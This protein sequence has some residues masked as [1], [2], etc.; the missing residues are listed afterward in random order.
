VRSLFQSIQ[1]QVGKVASGIDSPLLGELPVEQLAAPTLGHLL[2]EDFEIQRPTSQSL[3]SQ[4]PNCT[5]RRK[6]FLFI[7]P[8]HRSMELLRRPNVYERSP[9][10]Q[11]RDELEIQ[12][13]AVE[14][15]PCRG[16]NWTLQRK[17]VV[18]VQPTQKSVELPRK[19]NVFERSLG[20]EVR[21]F[22]IGA[23]RWNMPVGPLGQSS[24]PF[25]AEFDF[26]EIERRMK[27]SAGR[28]RIRPLTEPS[29][30]SDN[31]NPRLNRNPDL[32]NRDCL[33]LLLA[34]FKVSDDLHKRLFRSARVDGKR[35][36]TKPMPTEEGAA[37]DKLETPRL[38]FGSLGLGNRK[39]FEQARG[40]ITRGMS[41]WDLLLPL[42][43]RPVNLDLG[44]VVDLPS[45]LYPYQTKGV[46]FL[47]ETSSA[48]LGDDMG[49]G[50]TV[51][52][53][54]AL[55]MMFQTG[56]LRTALIVCPLSVIPNWD[57]EL[58]KWAGNLAVTVVRGDKEHRKICWRQ[59]SHLWL[60][61]Y[62]TLRNDL[63]NVLALRKGG[64][65]LVVLDE[66]Q[67][68]KNWS[69]GVTRAVR[70]L[71]A[72]YRWGLT[73]T[74]L[75][76]NTNELW[77]IL[78]VLKPDI[79]KGPLDWSEGIRSVLRPMFLRRR[80]QD[81]LTDLPPLVQNPVWLRLEDE[82]RRSYHELEERGVLELHAKG[83]SITAQ[84]IIVLLNKLKQVCNRCPRSGESSKL[85]WLLD[86]LDSIAGERDKALV[87]SQYTD[88]R[89]A[90][91]DWL[92]TELADFG[93]LNYSKATSDTKR[94]AVLEAFK[95]KPQH[96][97]F[98]GHPKTAGLGLNEL[99]AANY[100]IHF[101]HW[102]NPAVMN[103]A[104]ARAH[105]PGQ[106][107]PV[108]AYDLW[109]EDTYEEIIF[110]L[111]ERKQGLYNEVI[112]SMSAQR[113]PSDSLAFAVADTLF[114]KYGLSPIQRK[115]TS[116]PEQN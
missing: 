78:N 37:R 64:F 76:N 94:R 104:T 115:L 15:F 89:F 73:G 33:T 46:E 109:I 24:P 103:Q 5:L 20:I 42:L 52:T 69:A 74:P 12:R 100:V 59:T 39:A 38:A 81:V 66:A 87:F 49:T 16:L 88:E 45:S 22:G 8:S 75:E 56:K 2:R 95:E 14:P 58:A 106:T 110:R 90:G 57:R 111:L 17:E 28:N 112:D 97:V 35:Y 79:S 32:G 113:E 36:T 101:D 82:Q 91:A 23:S 63:E 40:R 10:V 114:A 65:D 50:K 85:I 105:R 9:G 51:Q 4:G 34:P 102:W 1:K 48:L 99:V 84:I 71:R 47:V 62:D 96:K 11:D 92:E 77:T 108:F 19:A 53:S 30:V 31:L 83:E 3:P 26:K 61:T 107:K 13:P 29:D 54:V 80:K 70:E 18:L 55:R 21:T 27:A 25:L 93:A 72:T 67:R 43:Q 7:Q 86:S 116:R 44:T 98:I 60:T 68:V 41:V 6:E